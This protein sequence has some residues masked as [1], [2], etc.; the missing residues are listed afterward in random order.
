MNFPFLQNLLR[1]TRGNSPVLEDKEFLG[2]DLIY[3]FNNDTQVLIECLEDHNQIEFKKTVGYSDQTYWFY[4]EFSEKH[5]GLGLQS[6]QRQSQL[7]LRFFPNHM[8]IQEGDIFSLFFKDNTGLAF[9][10]D[11]P[12]KKKNRLEVVFYQVNLNFNELD[13]NKLVSEP[14][15]GW[16]HHQ[17]GKPLKK[18]P[19]ELEEQFI[20]K[21]IFQCYQECI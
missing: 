9:L 1:F 2:S 20:L 14:I 4:D 6:I 11:Q 16:C 3:H 18:S 7:L 10:V 17:N 21:R 5:F 13:L 8:T 12:P 15:V 19:F